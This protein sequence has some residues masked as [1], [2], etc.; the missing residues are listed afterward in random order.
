MNV[1]YVLEFDGVPVLIFLPLSI[2][3]HIEFSTMSWHSLWN[4]SSPTIPECLRTAEAKLLSHSRH[5]G[6]Q[7]KIEDR[8]FVL[9]KNAVKHVDSPLT[10]HAIQV[11]NPEV[12]AHEAPLVM[13][14]GYSTYYRLVHA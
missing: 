11:T 4:S 2:T 7:L 14:H 1:F 5:E 12:P 6:P 3:K 10:L 13:L 8:D 9:P